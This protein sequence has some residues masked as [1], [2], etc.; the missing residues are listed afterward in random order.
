MINKINE[1]LNSK[2]RD[3]LKTWTKIS[4]DKTNKISMVIS[5][6]KG[7]DFDQ[8]IVKLWYK[9]NKKENSNQPRCVDG[10]SIKKEIYFIEFKNGKI[11]QDTCIDLRLKA[12]ETLPE[13]NKI[14]KEGIKDIGIDDFFKLDKSFILVY[15]PEK[16]INTNPHKAHLEECEHFSNAKNFLEKFKDLYYKDIIIMNMKEFKKYFLK[17]E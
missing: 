6:Q 4:E 17:E 10:V 3:Q 13:F 12:V 14:L 16:I 2:Y 7:F 9:K 8:G 11:E 1:H 15:N 5:E